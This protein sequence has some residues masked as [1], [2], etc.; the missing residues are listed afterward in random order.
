MI[1]ADKKGHLKAVVPVLID[2][3]RGITIRA[4]TI[5]DQKV[6]EACVAI[7]N[8]DPVPGCY[9][10]QLIKDKRGFIK[11]FEINP[12]ISTTAC[13]CFAAGVDFIGI[14]M[15]DQKNGVV[16]EFQSGIQLIRSWYNEFIS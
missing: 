11:P 8:S 2:R 1:A 10:V 4:A 5:Y 9:N 7:H 15:G 13:L 3:K 14:Y 6:I 16:T 12:R